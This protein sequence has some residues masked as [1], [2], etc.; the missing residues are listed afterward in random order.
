MSFNQDIVTEALADLR[1]AKAL[2]QANEAALN[3]EEI[4]PNTR[5]QCEEAIEKA[6]RQ[7]FAAKVRIH[8]QL[9]ILKIDLQDAEEEYLMFEGSDLELY[10][11]IEQMKILLHTTETQRDHATS[12]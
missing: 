10:A 4:H 3:N 12:N 9:R 1:Q 6:N 11:S 8:D 5:R 7:S 2:K